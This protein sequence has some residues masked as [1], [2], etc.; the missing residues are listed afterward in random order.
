MSTTALPRGSATVARAK[1]LAAV[2]SSSAAAPVSASRADI[3]A[4]A[5]KSGIT[6]SGIINLER[7]RRRWSTG[8]SLL[9]L[10]GALFV[11]VAVPAAMPD[12]DARPGDE[13]QASASPRT[14]ANDGEYIGSE[15]C[16][17]C[18]EPEYDS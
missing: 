6:L 12:R 5:R 11:A 14:G 7:M 16:R 3:S 9:I 2:W 10:A 8:P 1:R 4:H 18:H 13:I 17:R 15:A